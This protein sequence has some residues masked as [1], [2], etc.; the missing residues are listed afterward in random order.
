MPDYSLRTKAKFF[1]LLTMLGLVLSLDEEA[2]KNTSMATEEM[3]KISQSIAKLQVSLDRVWSQDQVQF[4][5]AWIKS[6]QKIGLSQPLLE[7][8]QHLQSYDLARIAIP[9]WP[10]LYLVF[11]TIP[12]QVRSGKI[13]LKDI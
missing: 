10:L 9:N 6:V 11:P 5:L 7:I 13:P 8:V 2:L 1:F 3:A 4:F 12:E